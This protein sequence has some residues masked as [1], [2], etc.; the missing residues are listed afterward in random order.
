MLYEFLHTVLIELLK[1]K[2]RVIKAI[3]LLDER[4]D[5]FLFLDEKLLLLL[6]LGGEISE[7]LCFYL[8]HGKGLVWLPSRVGLL[9]G[10]NT[11]LVG[12]SSIIVF[13][14]IIGD[15]GSASLTE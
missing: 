6:A 13:L 15:Q 14:G 8:V 10:T 5:F 2:L 9:A 4:S 12:T 3:D 7:S 11:A 1:S